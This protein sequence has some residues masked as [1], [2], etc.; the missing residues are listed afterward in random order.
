[1]NI[2]E[3]R[4]DAAW[5]RFV[6]ALRP[7]TFLHS[8]NWR[9]MQETLGER[10]VPLGAYDG[11]RL[12][13]VALGVTVSAR[14][15]RFLF[16]P[17][18]PLADIRDPA[19][20]ATTQALLD[21]LAAAARAERCAFLRVSPLVPDTP[22]QRAWYAARGYRPAPLHMHAETMWVR[23]IR[24]SDE[25]MLRGMRKTTRNLIRRAE[26]EGVVVR[27]TRDTADFGIFQRLYSETAARERFVPFSADFLAAEF[28]AF[29]LHD[30]AF[31]A[32]ATHDGT[33][34]A[35][36]LIV[37]Y[38]SVGFYH[39]G[40]SSRARAKIP[41]AYLL[42][43]NIMRELRQRGITTY[44][45]WGIAPTA[46]PRHPWAGL[47]L[48]KQGFGGERRDYLHAQDLP[49]TPFYWFTAAIERLRRWVRRY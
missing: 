43:W 18:G 29:L 12:V 47:T 21:A 48:F 27:F 10:T 32:I 9:R 46:D 11:E 44:N 1:M 15:G 49:L 13:G 33:A 36:A 35:A 41:A 22:K 25:E 5:D 20:P 28:A 17:H 26:R 40:A 42:H 39:Q 24:L 38:G 30:R 2:R 8:A 23:H 31:L 45:F 34:L 37:T 16:C 19:S 4:D 7:N 14:R 3:V 6:I